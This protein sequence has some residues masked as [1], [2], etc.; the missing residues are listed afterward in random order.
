MWLENLGIHIEFVAASFM[1]TLAAQAYAYIIREPQFSPIPKLSG[2]FINRAL[3]YG[4][5][6]FAFFE[7]LYLFYQPPDDFQMN[8][9]FFGSVL[10]F[11]AFLLPLFRFGATFGE[12][13]TQQVRDNIR[14][15]LRVYGVLVTLASLVFLSAA[16]YTL[17]DPLV[18]HGFW[19]WL[20]LPF[21]AAGIA[22]GV[23]FVQVSFTFRL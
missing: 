3:L 13:H 5:Y 12:R 15:Y 9:G 14:P 2:T 7:L 6:M 23:R 8:L 1:L 10:A 16:L 11:I 4:A 20:E 21:Y 19:Y 22:T 18:Y 17:A